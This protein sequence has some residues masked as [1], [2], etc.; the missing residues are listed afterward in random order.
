MTN[1]D[2]KLRKQWRIGPLAV[3]A[4]IAFAGAVHA[5]P[6]P[7]D[8]AKGENPPNDQQRGRNGGRFDRQ[9]LRDMTPEQREQAMQQL[10]DTSLR[11]LLTRAGFADKETQDPIITFINEQGQARQALQDKNRKVVEALRAE[12]TDANISTLLSD[13]RQATADEKT[14]R[15]AAITALD[16]KINYTKKPRLEALLTVMGLVGDESALAGGIGGF[17]ARTGGGARGGGAFGGFGGGRGGRGDGA[18]DA[19]Q[20]NGAN[21]FG[22]GGGRNNRRGR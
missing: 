6:N 18:G 2:H 7:N 21:G 22:R 13:L 8:A 10:R 20:G 14:R 12:A 11:N 3:A 16:A 15:D 17:G 5:Q 9:R 4:S 1:A 19:A